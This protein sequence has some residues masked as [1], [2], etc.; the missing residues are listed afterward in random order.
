MAF[1]RYFPGHQALQDHFT[2]NTKDT[3]LAPSTELVLSEA[4][5]FSRLTALATWRSE[6]LFR[7]TLLSSLARGKPTKS[8]AGIESPLR[9]GSAGKKSTAVLTYNS[10]LPWTVTC[11]DA[12]FDNGSKG[13]RA[14]HGTSM[15]GV[16]TMSDPTNGKV[17]KWGFE[18]TNLD[19]D[20][21]GVGN[22]DNYHGLGSGP[23]ATNNVMDVSQAY[24]MIA[25]QGIPGGRAFYRAPLDKARMTLESNDGIPLGQANVPHVPSLLEGICGVW[26]A[27]SATLPT[28]SNSMVGMFTGSTLGIITAYA[29][30]TD[31]KLRQAYMTVRWAVSPGVPI[32]SIKVDDNYSIKRKASNRVWAVALNALGE[33]YYLTQLPVGLSPQ[34]ATGNSSID[35][36]KV[37]YE[38]PWK[39][40]QGTRRIASVNEIGQPSSLSTKE[41]HKALGLINDNTD[42]SVHNVPDINRVNELLRCDSAYF[43]QT[44]ENWAMIRRLEV[45]FAADDGQEAGEHI[46]VVNYPTGITRFTRSVKIIQVQRPEPILRPSIFGGSANVQQVAGSHLSNVVDRHNWVSQSLG[47]NLKNVNISA[48]ALDNSIP[49]LYTLAEDPLCTPQEGE[50]ADA[51]D[52]RIQRRIPGRRARYLVAGTECGAVFVWNSR[53]RQSD[54]DISPIRIIQTSSP[55][56]ECVAASSLYIV[57]GGSDG[58][59]QAWDPLASMSDAV[60]T[61]NSKSTGPIHR[62]LRNL[63]ALEAGFDCGTQAGAIFMDPDATNL[64]GIVAFGWLLKCWS[65]SAQ[66]PNKGRKRRTRHGDAHARLASRR[67]ANHVSDFIAEEEKEMIRSNEERR[68][69]MSRMQARFGAFGDLTE[70][71]ALEYAQILSSESYAADEQRRASDSGADTGA[72]LDT[73]S[74]FS[75]VTPEP[76]IIEQKSPVSMLTTD[77]EDEYDEHLQHALRLSLMETVEA[78]PS[79]RSQGTADFDFVV[80]YK[81]KGGR[82]TKTPR[83]GP[84]SPSGRILGN[85]SLRPGV[86]TYQMTTDD[87]LAFAISLSL[88]DQEGLAPL[89]SSLKSEDEFPALNHD[90]SGKG[91]GPM[92]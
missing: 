31:P 22:L 34:A 2:R 65:Y 33:V 44:Y 48:S 21:L 56:I 19:L 66:N 78:S 36:W 45:D 61:L 88:Q 26:V 12:V 25:G 67:Q 17:S 24:G 84:Q 63:P 74:S 55:A 9:A 50:K 70:E 10:R 32:I 37:G 51:D 87:D 73:V 81:P 80:K 42:N 28:I 14:I 60:R 15:F 72:D 83:S 16:A 6:Y 62:R 23:V 76:S 30:N 79:S 54:E 89:S 53:A 11:I 92:R 75:D 64:R 41:A 86:S 58:L 77:G 91:K 85:A 46:F 1:F 29:I 82:K 47:F 71:E 40:L 4:R 8:K 59:V 27:K 18:E 7:T 38:T 5:Y 35:A 57:H 68:R 52:E 90:L 69:E 39:L 20:G 49:S 13:P 43:R 3:S